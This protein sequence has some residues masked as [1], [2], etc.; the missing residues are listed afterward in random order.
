MPTTLS[1]PS[2]TR[3]TPKDPISTPSLSAVDPRPNPWIVTPPRPEPVPPAAPGCTSTTP[4]MNT[5][6]LLEVAAALAVP[7]ISMAGEPDGD[8]P[9]LVVP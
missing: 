8:A 5:P 4:L 7:K 3:T 1:G 6:W 9:V 2:W